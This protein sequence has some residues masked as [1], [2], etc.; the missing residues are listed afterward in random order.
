MAEAAIWIA[1]E[2]CGVLPSGVQPEVPHAR[3][4]LAQARGSAPRFVEVRYRHPVESTAGFEM[5]PGFESFQPIRSGQILA[6][7]RAGEVRTPLSGR[8][9][10]PLYQE[11]GEDGFFVVREVRPIWLRISAFLRRLQV[12]RA[13]HWL[14][15]VR[16]HPELPEAFLVD[17]RYARWPARQLFHLLGYRRVGRAKRVLTMVRRRDQLD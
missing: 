16:R 15:G 12:D 3:W 4:V 14:P 9:L 11:Q 5:V 7:S 6:A 13:L 17:R 8:I 1:L 2:S 10:M